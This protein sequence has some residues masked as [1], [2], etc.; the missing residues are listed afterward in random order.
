MNIEEM[1]QD[2]DVLGHIRTRN[3]E[4]KRRAQEE[5]WTT[6]PLSESIADRFET[7]YDFEKDMALQTYSDVYKESRGFR[8]SIDPKWTL[9]EIRAKTERLYERA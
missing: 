5:G 2:T 1:K 4:R 7:V 8:P 9:E 3:E 6:F